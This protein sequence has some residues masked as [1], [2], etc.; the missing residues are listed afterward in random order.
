MKDLSIHQKIK[1]EFQ[2][3]LLQITKV[4]PLILWDHGMLYLW[5][6][7]MTGLMHLKAPLHRHRNYHPC[8]QA[9]VAI[10]LTCENS[11]GGVMDK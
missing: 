4:A 10:T 3:V 1:V 2:L 9:S 6:L 8:T 7:L 5:Q 11:S